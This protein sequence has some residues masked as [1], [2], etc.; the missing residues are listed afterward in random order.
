MATYMIK[1]AILKP[2]YI[3]LNLWKMRN[4]QAV[5]R[6]YLRNKSYIKRGL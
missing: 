5:P 3:G 4:V 1:K 2:V 6:C